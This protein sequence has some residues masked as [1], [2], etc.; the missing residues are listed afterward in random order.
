MAGG[1]HPHRFLKFFLRMG[2]AFSP[3]KIF[4]CSLI[5]GTSAHEK[6]C[7]IGPTVLVPKFDEGS[8]LGEGGNHPHG[9][10]F[11]YLSYH[12]DDIQS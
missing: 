11:T 1:G 7:Q 4:S 10:L 12:E 3:N 9:L 6:N 5:L 2:R 8:V